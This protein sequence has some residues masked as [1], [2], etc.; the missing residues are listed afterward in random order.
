MIHASRF[1][2]ALALFLEWCESS[3]ELT[4]DAQ[5]LA[6]QAALH[7]GEFG[8]AGTL[9][10]EAQPQ[11]RARGDEDGVLDCANLLGAV[12]FER[13][14][15]DEAEAQFKSV[16]QSAEGKGRSRFTARSAN[17]LAVIA[18]MRGEREYA[19]A[20]YQKALTA[21]HQI[22]DERG[23]IETWHNLVLS[24]RE[25]RG[26]QDSFVTCARALEAAER[27]GAGGLIAL[28]LLGRAELLIERNALDEAAADIDRAR[29]LAWLEGNEP[30]ALDSERLQALLALRRGEP[31]RA[32]HQAE[33][34]MVRARS[35]GCA[36]IAAESATIAA[37]ALKADQRP[38]EAAIAN[39]LAVAALVARGAPSRLESHARAW[40]DTAA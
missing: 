18:H 35:S 36:W 12:A 38:S 8:L 26:S 17:N 4:P 1:R 34:I 20:L 9:A 31:R 22:G 37:L 21:Y 5:L 24:N 29:Q 3:V 32:H 11:L 25:G 33:Q 27:L 13:G 40:R 2:E 19:A 7:I 16:M 23:I 15:V 28:T 39:D 30:H 14:N 6:A 10:A